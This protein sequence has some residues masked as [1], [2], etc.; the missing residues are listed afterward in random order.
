MN[1]VDQM[2]A[3]P[4]IPY[5]LLPKHFKPK[6]ISNNRNQQKSNLLNDNDDN[7]RRSQRQKH[8]KDNGQ[9]REQI[10]YR[11]FVPT[12]RY[13]EPCRR[14]YYNS[15]SY[16]PPQ[17]RSHLSKNTILS[18]EINRWQEPYI[19]SQQQRNGFRN[20]DGCIREDHRIN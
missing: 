2:I 5:A 14:D 9:G 15:Y 16:Q 8:F 19:R 11:E 1:V 20:N 6:Q 4:H 7:T 13:Y 10:I 12:N 17:N 18:Y 3:Q